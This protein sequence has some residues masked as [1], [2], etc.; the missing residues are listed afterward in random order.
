[1][2][3]SEEAEAAPYKAHQLLFGVRWNLKS[4]TSNSEAGGGGV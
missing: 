1:M 4:H 3:L 2:N